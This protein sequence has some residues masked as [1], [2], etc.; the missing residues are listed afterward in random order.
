MYKVVRRNTQNQ[1]FYPK[2]QWN[3]NKSWQ[4]E[5]KK[6]HLTLKWSTHESNV[7]SFYT[8]KS[9][10]TLPELYCPGIFAEVAIAYLWNTFLASFVKVFLSNCLYTAISWTLSPILSFYYIRYRVKRPNFLAH[11]ISRYD[12][13]HSPLHWYRFLRRTAEKACGIYSLF[14]G[15]IRVPNVE[16]R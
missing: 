11:K 7:S 8:W 5:I 14:H 3:G 16:M 10:S 15:E 13:L 2:H 4:T 9:V 1:S 6:F 12:T